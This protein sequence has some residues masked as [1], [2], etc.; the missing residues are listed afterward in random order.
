F[1]TERVMDIAAARLGIDPAEIRRRNYVPTT[2]FPYRSVA[3][4]VYDSG[5]YPRALDEALRIAD[6]TGLRAMQARAR[7][8]GRL[9]GIG[10]ANYVEVTGMGPSKLMAA[11]GNRQG[12]YEGAAVRVEPSGRVAVA[13]GVIRLG[14]GIRSALAQVAADVLSLPYERVSVV[15]GDTAR[16]P[17]SCYGTADSRGSVTGG[18]AVLQ[19]TRALRQKL[20]RVAARLLEAD[21]ADLEVV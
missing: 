16:T 3:N 13:A 21:E 10:V 14:Q 18:A 12:G 17:Y 15:L 9:V 8:E 11:M 1:V 6:Y 2:A 5:D 7:A 4:L 19:A 20:V